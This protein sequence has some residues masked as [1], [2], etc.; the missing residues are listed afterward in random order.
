MSSIG[1]ALAAGL[2]FLYARVLRPRILTWGYRMSFAI[3]EPEHVLATRSAD[4]SW[5]WTFVLEERDGTT[6]LLS[7]N[8]FR[9][10]KPKDRLGISRWSPARS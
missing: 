8:R 5:V 6:R 10:P 4:G 7:R 3:V 1:A 9:L 2:A